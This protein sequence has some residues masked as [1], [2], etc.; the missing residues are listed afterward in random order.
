LEKLEFILKEHFERARVCNESSRAIVFSQL[1]DSV[2]EIVGVLT[3][4]A[5]LVLATK[6]VGQGSGNLIEDTST[7]N[8]KRT[9]STKVAGMNQKEQQR[10]IKEFRDGKFNVL[11][12]TCKLLFSL[13][14]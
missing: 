12:C 9:R 4:L 2:E 13:I 7:P 6:F 8:T 11:V 3:G 1:R 5:P 10:V 14:I